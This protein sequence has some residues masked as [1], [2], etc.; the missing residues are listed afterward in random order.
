MRSRKGLDLLRSPEFEDCYSGILCTID[1]TNDP[2]RTYEALLKFSPPALDLLLP[3]ANWSSPS[4]R[5]GVRRL[6]DHASSSAGT[7]RPGRRPGFACSASSSSSYSVHPGEVEGLGLLPSTLIVVDTDGS[8][9]QLDSLS[10]AYP[11]AADVGLHVMTGS[12]RR[13]A[14]TTRRRWPGRSAWTRFP[15]SAWQCPVHGDLRRRPLPAPLP[16]G[17]GFRNPSVYCEDLL[18]LIT[19][20][21]DRVLTD[22]AVLASP[23]SDTRQRD[24]S[25]DFSARCSCCPRSSMDVHR[26]LAQD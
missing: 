14:R 25:H 22:L 12:F 13:R 5:R 24:L 7:P 21:R 8:I 9:K 16:G 11:G 18:R 26:C 19:H 6:A 15:R 3:H 4:A 23:E 1:V 2:L 17:E 10:S 20:V